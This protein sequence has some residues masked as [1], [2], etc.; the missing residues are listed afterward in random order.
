[1]AQLPAYTPPTMGTPY[2]NFS[3]IEEFAQHAKKQPRT[4]IIQAIAAERQNLSPY[5]NL[6]RK[7]QAQYPTLGD[8]DRD[9]WLLDRFIAEGHPPYEMTMQGKKLEYLKRVFDSIRDDLKGRGD[10]PKS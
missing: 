9:L 5:M 1:M 3:S 2:S 7:Q 4:A 10:W 8:Y 6:A